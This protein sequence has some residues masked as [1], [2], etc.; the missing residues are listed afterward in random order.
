MGAHRVDFHCDVTFMEK[1]LWLKLLDSAIKGGCV[2]DT[3]QP[4]TQECSQMSETGA[5]LSVPGDGNESLAMTLKL[6]RGGGRAL[7][8]RRGRG[9]AAAF[10]VAA[11]FATCVYSVSGR[12]GLPTPGTIAPLSGDGGGGYASVSQLSCDKRNFNVH[13]CSQRPVLAIHQLWYLRRQR[14]GD[15]TWQISRINSLGS[16]RASDCLVTSGC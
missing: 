4:S 11:T 3:W 16:T 1:N 12:A 9:R 2:L 5:L 10:L 8:M 14:P 15:V 7:I 13:T 6:S